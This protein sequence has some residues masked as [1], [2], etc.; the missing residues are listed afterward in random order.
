MFGTA[1]TWKATLQSVVA[2]STTEAEFTAVTEAIKEA[3]WLKGFISELGIRQDKVVVHCDSQSAIHLSKHQV[4]HER[5]KHIDVKMH[6]VR[7]VLAKGDVSLEKI[8]T[9]DNPADMLRKSLPQ[10]KFKH[11]LN[12]V[13]AG[14]FR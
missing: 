2:L 13:N 9:G 6:F 8:S 10:A 12:L 3:L 7:D 1:I 5:S 11:C 4:Y 14:K